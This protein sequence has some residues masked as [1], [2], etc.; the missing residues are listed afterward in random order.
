MSGG[1]IVQVGYL[2][3]DLDRAVS[4]RLHAFNLGPWLIFRN[5]ELEG[6][7]RGQ[8][9]TV[10]IDVALAYQGDLQIELIQLR[11]ETPSPYA[12]ADGPILGLHHVATLVDDLDAAVAEAQGKGLRPVFVAGNAAVRVAYLESDEPGALFELIEGKDM[13]AM[14]EAGIAEAANWDGSNPVRVIDLAAVG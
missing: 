14:I 10:R 13:A 2:V 6:L 3:A 9:T 8:P 12:D 7:Y 5:T 11:S 1:G 4:G